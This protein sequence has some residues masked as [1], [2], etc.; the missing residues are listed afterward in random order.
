M[1]TFILISGMLMTSILAMNNANATAVTS[2]PP[3]RI[4]DSLGCLQIAEQISTYYGNWVQAIQDKNRYLTE[5]PDYPHGAMDYANTV[6]SWRYLEL[7][8]VVN[9]MQECVLKAGTI[10]GT[11][12]YE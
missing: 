11:T 7:I 6:V 12:V 10:P 9:I 4:P 3:N 8:N 5:N 2:I 1:K